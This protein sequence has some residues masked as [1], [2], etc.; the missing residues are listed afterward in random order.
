MRRNIEKKGNID[1]T[2]L[3]IYVT[4]VLIGWMTVYSAGY[5]PEDPNI[6]N[7]KQTY[8]KQ[9]I[10]MCF[11]TLLG[12]VIFNIDSKFF[13]SLAFVYYTITL[14]LLIIVYFTARDI[15]GAKAWIDLG[16]FRLQPSEFCKFT[17]A[18]ALSKFLSELHISIDNKKHLITSILIIII[19]FGLILLQHDMGSAL[20]FTSFVFVLHRNGLSS[21]IISTGFYAIFLSVLALILKPFII[22]ICLFVLFSIILYFNLKKRNFKQLLNFFIL[23][24]L[25]SSVYVFSVDYI[26]NKLEKHQKDRINV[27]LG[28]GGNDWNIRQSRIALGSGQFWGKGF[29]KG[30]QSKGN[31]LPAKETDFIFCTIGEEWGFV[32]CFIVLGLYVILLWRILDLA[33]KQKSKFA[34]IYGYCIVGIIFFHFFIN[35]GMTVGLVPVIGIPLPAVSYGGSS[36]ITFTLLILVFL[37]LDSERN[38]Y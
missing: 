27:M 19:P 9:F 10:W 31:F 15:N 8:G 3:L 2:V 32:G 35:I 22:I 4:L 12:I 20:V 17:T 16:F 30:T 26:F 5:H 38:K 33:E 36:L 1:W 14:I 13:S 7:F 21:W 24:W 29:L 6:F 25:A 23:V 34:K 11:C 37:K 18:L 28:K